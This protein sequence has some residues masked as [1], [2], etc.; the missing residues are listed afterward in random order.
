[1]VRLSSWFIIEADHLFTA[2]SQVEVGESQVINIR[3]TDGRLGPLVFALVAMGV[4]TLVAT[5]LYWWATR[6]SRAVENVSSQPG[7]VND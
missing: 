6:P 7:V 4:A 5:G 3:E 1:M 2:A